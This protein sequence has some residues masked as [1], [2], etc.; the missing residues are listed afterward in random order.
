MMSR[1]HMLG[2]LV[3][4]DVVGFQGRGAQFC[5]RDLILQVRFFFVYTLKLFRPS[6]NDSAPRT[7]HLKVIF[8]TNLSS[9]LVDEVLQLLVCWRLGKSSW[10]NIVLI[11]SELLLTL[12]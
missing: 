6:L 7:I 8:R 5:N 4:D 1:H 11:C 9:C 12:Y 10:T 2:C 3:H